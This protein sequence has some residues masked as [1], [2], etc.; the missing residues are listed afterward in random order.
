LASR[1]DY[2]YYV[3]HNSS[4]SNVMREIIYE[5][6]GKISYSLLQQQLAVAQENLV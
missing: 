3:C 4:H 5:I 1:K 6:T 2:C